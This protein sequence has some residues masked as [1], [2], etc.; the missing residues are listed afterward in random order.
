LNSILVAG[1]RIVILALVSYSIAIIT[2]QRKQLVTRTVL[3]FI[4]MGIILDIVAT[5]FMILG[6]SNTPFT[7]HGILGYS[8][9]TAMLI[10]AALLWR[11]QLKF[12]SLTKV[13]KALHLYSRVA[14]IWWI[15][16]FITGALLVFLK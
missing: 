11:H 7:L 15:L 14:Y 16:A 8:S 1:T 6:S 9:L 3:I 12:N 5:L 13:P 4:S 2:E 10:D